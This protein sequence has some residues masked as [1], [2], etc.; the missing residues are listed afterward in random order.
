MGDHYDLF[1][2]IQESRL[3]GYSLL[4]SVEFNMFSFDFIYVYNI[5]LELVPI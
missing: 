3:M 2:D 4:K 5:V 1:N